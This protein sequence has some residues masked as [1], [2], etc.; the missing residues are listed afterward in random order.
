MS[1]GTIVTIVLLMSVLI[2]GI[3]LVQKVFRSGS[4]AIDSI[5]NQVQ[6]EITKLFSEEGKRFVVYPTSQ[7]LTIRKGDDPRGFAFSLKNTFPETRTFS[8]NVEA[9]DVTGCGSLTETQASSWLR[10]SKGELKIG[11]GN[12]PTLPELVLLVIPE[13]A[14][15]CTVTYRISVEDESEE[16]TD[17]APIYIT[18][19]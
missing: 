15:P 19:Q 9:T 1:V 14:P 2:L 11:A 18:V 16:F 6:S 17:G 10:N 12:T 5:D 13:S 3:F 4:N 7:Q 8:Y